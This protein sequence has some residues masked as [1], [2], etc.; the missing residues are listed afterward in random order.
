M[1]E[2]RSHD[3]DTE[4]EITEEERNRKDGGDHDAD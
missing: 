2:I 4:C 3:G 1:R